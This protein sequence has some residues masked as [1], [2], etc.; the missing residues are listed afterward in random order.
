MKE[1]KLTR[2]ERAFCVNYLK[3]GDVQGAVKA[4]GY[5][6]DAEAVAHRLLTREDVRAEI[7]SLCEFRRAVSREIARG[8]YERLAFGNIADAVSLL[9][10][11]NPEREDLEGMDLFCISE[12]KRPKD[13][14]MEIKFFDRLKA[15]QNLF[16][17]EDEGKKED[18]SSSIFDAIT[19]GAAALCKKSEEGANG[20]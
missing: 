10:M 6:G 19:M 11:D 15:L 2:K 13:G 9:Y 1:R 12:I 4:A 20:D 17:K 16:E 7:L 5:K 18:T 3:L 8:G 14:A